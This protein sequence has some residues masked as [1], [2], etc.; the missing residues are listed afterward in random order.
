M[1]MK[2]VAK[3]VGLSLRTLKYWW[4]AY[5]RTGSVSKKKRTGRPKFLGRVE[6]MIISKHVG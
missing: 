6:K 1:K 4:S 5:K 2:M 3:A